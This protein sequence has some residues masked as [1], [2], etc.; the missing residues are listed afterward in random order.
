MNEIFRFMSFCDGKEQAP[1][2]A[3]KKRMYFG[4]Y[5]QSFRDAYRT[6]AR[7]LRQDSMRDVTSFMQAVFEIEERHRRARAGNRKRFRL[8]RRFSDEESVSGSSD[9]ESDDGGRKHRRLSYGRGRGR[10]ESRENRGR[11]NQHHGGRF[12]EDDGRRERNKSQQNGRRGPKVRDEDQCPLHDHPHTWGECR[13]HP[14]NRNNRFNDKRQERD[15]KFRGKE[16]T[17]A[18]NN[19]GNGK[20]SRDNHHDNF[21]VDNAENKNNNKSSNRD[22]EQH[23]FDLIGS[24]ENTRLGARDYF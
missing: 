20:E 2:E 8:Q 13:L 6:S 18:N 19:G 10:R 16:S 9:D 21:F 15:N 14:K 4:T 5:P 23:H 7:S 11:N 1:D 17:N 24:L 22:D 12:R 3:A